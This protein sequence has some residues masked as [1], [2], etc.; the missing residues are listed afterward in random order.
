MSGTPVI[1]RETVEMLREMDEITEDNLMLELID[2]F[3]THCAQLVR[4]IE[5]C[6]LQDLVAKLASVS[7]SLKGAS[8]NIGALV[9]FKVCDKIELLARNHQLNE[10]KTEIPHLLIAFQ[11]TYHALTELRR[12]IVEGE[13]IDDLLSEDLIPLEY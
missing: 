13:A 9:L 1:D 6:A 11:D 4:E 7:H 3:L 2:D 10:A 5:E 8:L 12:R